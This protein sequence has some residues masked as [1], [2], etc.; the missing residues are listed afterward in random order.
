MNTTPEGAAQPAGASSQPAV[1][2]EGTSTNGVATDA[3]PAWEAATAYSIEGFEPDDPWNAVLCMEG[4]TTEVV[5]ELTPTHLD[6]LVNGLAE[7][8]HAQ[9][10]ALGASDTRPEH[11]ADGDEPPPDETG[12]AATDRASTLERV[13]HAARVATGSAPVARLWNS[14][15]RGRLIV[16]GGALTFVLLGV[17]LSVVSQYR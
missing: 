10:A 15:N 13:A 4:R 14:G 12:T 9:R 7:V 8:R 2:S 6:R 17:I 1:R 16:I 3:E 5:L 11:E